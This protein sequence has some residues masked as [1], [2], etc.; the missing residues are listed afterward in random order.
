MPRHHCATAT[1][2][3]PK[4]CCS[5]WRARDYPNSTCRSS[6]RSLTGIPDDRQRQDPEARADAMGEQ[7]PLAT[8]TRALSRRLTMIEL[9]HDEEFAVLTI[10]RPAAL[11]ALSFE[12]IGADRRQASAR[13][14]A[15]ARG[16]SSSPAR[17]RRRSAP[18]PTSRSC[19]SAGW[20]RSAKAPSWV[21]RCSRCSTGCPFRPSRS[22]TA[23]RSAAAASW[24]S[25]CTLA[26]GAA[27]CEVRSARKSSS[28]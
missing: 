15:R 10:R 19:S 14:G 12:L 28:A 22:S 23:S 25:R 16:R 1:H 20:P 21:K 8:A 26:A 3:T 17:A 9:T 11:N 18:A 2:R 27:E 13:R 24:R 7:R 6:S 4:R 5:T